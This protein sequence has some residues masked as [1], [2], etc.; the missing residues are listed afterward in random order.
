[1]FVTSFY[2]RPEE[3]QSI[4]VKMLARFS[5]CFLTGI[6][7]SFTIQLGSYLVE[8]EESSV[9]SLVVAILSTL[10]TLH[11]I[12]TCCKHVSDVLAADNMKQEAQ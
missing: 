10:E 11:M 9:F 2:L 7:E 12:N 1:M 6:E 3:N 5:T 8:S 4:L